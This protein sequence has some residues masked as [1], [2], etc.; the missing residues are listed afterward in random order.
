MNRLSSTSEK[1]EHLLERCSPCHED[2]PIRMTASIPMVAPKHQNNDIYDCEKSL[3]D[4][5]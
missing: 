2:K 3:S 1:Y 5:G 4:L